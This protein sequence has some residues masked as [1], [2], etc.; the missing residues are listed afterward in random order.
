[1]KQACH[2]PCLVLSSEGR[3]NPPYA[4]GATFS[5]SYY[6]R[7]DHPGDV[8]LLLQRAVAG[9]PGA[10]WVR[11][12]DRDFQPIAQLDTAAFGHS[13]PHLDDPVDLLA[14]PGHTQ[15]HAL[16]HRYSV[17]HLDAPSYRVAHRDL[18]AFAGP[19]RNPDPDGLQYA[20]ALADI[21]RHGYP[22][23]QSDPQCDRYTHSVTHCERYAGRP[24]IVRLSCNPDL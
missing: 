18:H 20:A 16:Q 11:S 23:V 4:P 3:K 6:F 19:F 15:P 14:N 13:P 10:Q 5:P 17:Q 21:Y 8:A 24:V 2:S 1:M 22:N 7:R 9:P 12:D